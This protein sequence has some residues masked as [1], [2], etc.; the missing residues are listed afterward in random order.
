MRDKGFWIAVA[1][2]IIMWS[3]GALQAAERPVGL[4]MYEEQLQGLCAADEIRRLPVVGYGHVQLE[5][6]EEG[7]VTLYDMSTP[8]EAYGAFDIVDAAL[9]DGF[10][11]LMSVDGVA[12]FYIAEVIGWGL[13]VPPGSTRKNAVTFRD[14]AKVMEICHQ[15][16]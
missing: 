1:A 12:F 6:N 4:T 10:F 14:G 8:I 5:Q 15:S 3:G 2:M 16:P 7:N 9:P 11:A 13:D